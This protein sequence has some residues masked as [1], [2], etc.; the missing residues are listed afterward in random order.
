M[1]PLQ[2]PQL[3][4]PSIPVDISLI[5]V[6]VLGGVLAF[7]LV[8][9]M[10]LKVKPPCPGRELG[11]VEW[12]VF[13]K[14]LEYEGFTVEAKQYASEWAAES[15][16]NL[17]ALSDKKRA[18]VFG[19]LKDVIGS[20]KTFVYATRVSDTSSLVKAHASK[21]LV[22]IN[23]DAEQYGN[24]K[25][26]Q[27]KWFPPRRETK[28]TVYLS[29][30]TEYFGERNG[31][32]VLVG[33]VIDQKTGREVKSDWSVEDRKTM[34]EIIPLLA[35]FVKKET[36]LNEEKA[37]RH[38]AEEGYERMKK[39]SEELRAKLTDA[40]RAL[41]QTPLDG[42]QPMGPLTPRVSDMLYGVAAAFMGWATASMVIPKAFPTVGILESGAIGILLGG[43]LLWW[44]KR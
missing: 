26:S 15:V 36:L 8:A 10:L 30:T 25:A 12:E 42:S 21:I 35:D 18:D 19:K 32:G 22:I 23:Q 3:P 38:A 13:S 2:L 44:Y 34:A 28:R 41:A 1:T 17:L 7:V 4:I 29:P 39:E 14:G 5:L 9:L 20:E 24:V 6:I 37:K 27:M 16:Q 31:F 40:E 33:E 43:F 11:V